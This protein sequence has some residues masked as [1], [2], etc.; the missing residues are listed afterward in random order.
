MLNGYSIYA[1]FLRC[2]VL[3]KA[4]FLSTLFSGEIMKSTTC[5]ACLAAAALILLIGCGASTPDQANPVQA[6]RDMHAALKKTTDP[7]DNATIALGKDLQRLD[8]REITA[9]RVMPALDSVIEKCAK[10]EAA[11]KELAIPKG[12]PEGTANMCGLLAEQAS[13]VYAKRGQAM[14]ALAAYLAK[15]EAAELSR[16]EKLMAESMQHTKNM[17][18]CLDKALQKAKTTSS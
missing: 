18:H 2:L 9:R 14:K 16:Y 17:K 7:A 10:A 8:K 13:Q 4:Y 5:L 12:L 1:S 15:G 6:V 11:A 3:E